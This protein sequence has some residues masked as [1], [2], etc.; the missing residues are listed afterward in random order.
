MWNN[1]WELDATNRFVSQAT[2][3][4]SLSTKPLTNTN[5]FAGN[6]KIIAHFSGSVFKPNK[7]IPCSCDFTSLFMSRKIS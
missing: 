6:L 3:Q 1:Y 2:E 4:L 5:N 7:Y